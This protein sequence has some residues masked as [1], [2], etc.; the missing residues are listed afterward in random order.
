MGLIELLLVCIGISFDVLAVSVC[1]GAVLM[2]I[3]KV[4]TFKM[5]SIFCIT[6][7][8]AAT[9]GHLFVF[10]PMFR[11]RAESTST[12]YSFCSIVL[13]LALGFFLLYKSRKNADILERRSELDLRKV[14]L[15]AV[16]TSVDSLFAGLLFSFMD[17]NIFISLSC[18]LVVTALAVVIGLYVG[19]RL[20]Y[21]PKKNAYI[22]G[23][24]VLLVAAIDVFI[25]I[26][27]E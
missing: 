7:L 14:R 22:I 21:E 13:M 15:S 11:N 24:S 8:V 12:L 18:L 9:I 16:F 3:D 23:A 2:E 19:Y 1:Y 17:A 26:F 4:K 20:G 6:Q 27:A 10:M 25:R 5:T